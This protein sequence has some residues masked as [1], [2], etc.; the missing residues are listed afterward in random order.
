LFMDVFKIYRFTYALNIVIIAYI[1][2][3]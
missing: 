3:A 2:Y 1:F